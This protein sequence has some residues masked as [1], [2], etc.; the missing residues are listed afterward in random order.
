MR[1]TEEVFLNS[2]KGFVAE[3]GRNQSIGGAFWWCDATR[4]RADEARLLAVIRRSFEVGTADGR[5]R[6][7]WISII[8]IIGH[9]MDS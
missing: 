4:S 1:K 5:S 2:C 8:E 7:H 3:K 9:R 6:D